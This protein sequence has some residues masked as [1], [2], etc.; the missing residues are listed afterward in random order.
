MLTMPSYKSE[1][2]DADTSALREV[3]LVSVTY[4]SA[5]LLEYFK[6]TA[7]QFPHVVVIDNHSED[8]SVERLKH[9]L[10]HAQ[11]ISLPRNIGFGPANNVGLA[12]VDPAIPY[13][14]FLNPDCRIKPADVLQLVRALKQNPDAAVACPVMQDGTGAIIRPKLRAYSQGYRHSMA[15]ALD[16]DLSQPQVV[17]GVCIDG[18]CFLVDAAKFRE[19]GGFDDRIFMY[20]EEDDIAL[21]MARRGYAVLLDTSASALHMRGTS[22]RNTMRVLIRRAYHF[23]W[24]K[25]YLTNTHLGVL[26]RLGG[27]AKYLTLSLPRMLWYLMSLDKPRLARAI[28]WFLASLDGIFMTRLFRFL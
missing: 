21:R 8:G 20:F 19:V 3:A 2:V 16:G 10:G 1:V 24:S 11:V 25:Y 23:R 12:Q 27:V 17:R 9:E 14:L 7:A 18:A 15:R 5:A 22:T 28:G 26:A 4:R 13:V 6:E